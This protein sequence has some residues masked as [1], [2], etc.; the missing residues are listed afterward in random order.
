MKLLQASVLLSV[1][2]SLSAMFADNCLGQ[3]SKVDS[4]STLLSAEKIDSSRV[5]LLWQLASQYQSFRPD[6]SLQLAQK[7]LLLARRIRF[8]EGESR[9]LA[10]L[11]TSQ[12]LLG[13]Y[14]KALNNYVLKL[15]I[16]EKRN[17]PRNYASAL[18]NIGLT[19][20]LLE[21]Y[22]NALAYLYRAD[23]TANTT[24]KETKQE[25]K[26]RIEV[27]IGEAY[28]RMGNVDSAAA[29]FNNAYSLAKESLDSASLGAAILGQANVLA[30]RNESQYALYKYQEA[31]AYLNDGSDIDI[32]CELSLGM[33]KA[34][35]KMNINDSA[36]YYGNMSYQLGESAKFLSRELDAALFLSG[37]FNK[38][39]NYDKAFAF[40]QKSV[41]LRD[42]LKG[43]EKI[44]AALIYSSD[45]KLRQQEIAEQKLRDKEAR[46][47]QLQWSII[48]ICIPV[49][50]IITLL[51]SRIKTHKR[52]VTFMGILSLLFLFE[53]LTLL[54]H[55]VVAR[56][57][58]HVPI[59]ELLIF[60]VIGALLV[61]SHH[62][63][64]H[65]LIRKLT[66]RNNDGSG[67]N[68]STKRMI[69]KTKK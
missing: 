67:L 54:L 11:A 65:I 45:E 50:F 69:F 19:Y 51:I 4:L 63:L 20:I 26:Y 3:S 21:D 24:D 66:R 56:L 59:F 62:K 42:S 38:S 61:P 31:Y 35:D 10:V 16:E 48:A 17:S 52:V 41:Q 36:A 57:T 37:V 40:L 55:P 1:A 34:F 29:Y 64:E 8:V 9:S 27:N 13:D 2:L 12:Y 15:K 60:V 47:K 49:L 68:I 23:S 46:S 25:L 18:N 58:H 22:S 5:T 28:Y 30:L 33:A 7:A 53:F 6:T 44:K 43:Q 32:L 14:P 39:R